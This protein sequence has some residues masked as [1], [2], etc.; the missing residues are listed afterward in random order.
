MQAR[1]P[2]NPVPQRSGMNSLQP[3][4]LPL[5]TVGRQE[6]ERPRALPA[7]GRKS[8]RTMKPPVALHDLLMQHNVPTMTLRY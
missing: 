8:L 7:V 2:E 4:A 5:R 1:L 6:S 3:A